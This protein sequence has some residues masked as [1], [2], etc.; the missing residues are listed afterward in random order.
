ME[1]FEGKNLGELVVVNKNK[2]RTKSKFQKSK[3]KRKNK[4]T[5][6]YCGKGFIQ[7]S[8][9]IVHKSF[10]KTIKYECTDCEK[11]FSTKENL[12]LHHKTESHVGEK[13]VE[14]NDKENILK[15]S[16]KSEN[17]ELRDTQELSNTD[18][19]DNSGFITD[20]ENGDANNVTTENMHVFTSTDELQ[21]LN[22]KELRDSLQCDRCNK[23]FQSK[24]RLEAHVKIV[25]LGEKPFV[26]EI[27]NKAFA[28]ESS[29]KGHLEIVHQV[30]LSLFLEIIEKI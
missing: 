28:Y 5:C 1:T 27:C 19:H 30:K 2:V 18:S 21:N 16:L 24:N 25:H 29:L 6:L 7:R 17:I 10:H 11:Q 26:C 13:I 15:D 12:F 9:Y 8:K 22:S 23:H 14:I 4:F 3:I 20:E